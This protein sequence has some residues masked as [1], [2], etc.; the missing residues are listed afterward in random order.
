M[1][2]RNSERG[3]KHPVTGASYESYCMHTMYESCR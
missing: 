1:D 2:V 3:G